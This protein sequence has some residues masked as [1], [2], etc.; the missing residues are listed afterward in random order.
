MERGRKANQ[1]HFI[2]SQASNLIKERLQQ[3]EDEKQA[4]LDQ[5]DGFAVEQSVSYRNNLEKA[6]KI[7]KLY[8]VQGKK[9]ADVRRYTRDML[10]EV[11]LSMLQK[12]ELSW[13]SI[14]DQ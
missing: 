13:P 9:Y 10:R 4:F 8:E 6:G 2:W 11:E 3:I 7:T 5:F 14:T 12:L 1:R